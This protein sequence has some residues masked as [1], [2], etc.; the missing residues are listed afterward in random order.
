MSGGQKREFGNL[1]MAILSLTIGM[2]DNEGT[3]IS[4]I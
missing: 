3:E 2:M 4:E 1:L